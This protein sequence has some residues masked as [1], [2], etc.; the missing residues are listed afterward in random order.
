VSF[1]RY[2]AIDDP[3]C[4]RGI[5]C[6]KNKLGLRDPVRLEAFELEM[7]SLRA[8]EPLPAGRFGPSYYRRVHWH[9]FQDVYRW[10]GRYRTIATAK[11]GNWFCYPEETGAGS[12]DG[13]FANHCPHCGATQ[14]DTLLHAEPGDVF[15]CIPLAEP[16]S[17]EFTRLSGRV[18]VSGDCGFGV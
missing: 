7:S 13:C 17:V 2:D 9:L 14:E 10:A 1:S 4:Y 3:Y 18:Q 11:G 6:L 15:F 8:Q 5:D 12:A 16:G